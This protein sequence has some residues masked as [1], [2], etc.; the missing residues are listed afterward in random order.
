MILYKN[1]RFHLGGLSFKLPEN[2]CL[3]PKETEYANPDG[4]IYTDATGKIQVITNTV[5]SEQTPAEY[6]KTEEFT[7]DVK[8]LGDVTEF[9]VD[10][11]KGACL[12]CESKKEECFEV[13]IELPV[14]GLEERLFTL[15]ALVEKGTIPIKEAAHSPTVTELLASIKQ[16][17]EWRMD[18]TKLL[19]HIT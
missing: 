1:N 6:F 18:F 10:G 7:V 15:C 17:P 11:I 13:A 12:Y 16:Y 5:Y 2:I 9:E 14:P 3:I 4:L 8:P 19:F